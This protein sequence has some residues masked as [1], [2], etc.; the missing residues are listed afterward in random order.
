MDNSSENYKNQSK[1]MN[2]FMLKKNLPKAFKQ[3]VRQYFDFV[4]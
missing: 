4:F 1:A 3:G 2:I